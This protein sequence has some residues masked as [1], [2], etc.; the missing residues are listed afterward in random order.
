MAPRSPDP[1]SG[2][3]LALI[4]SDGPEANGRPG[5]VRRGIL[6]ALGIEFPD[7]R[8]ERRLREELARARHAERLLSRVQ[9][10]AERAHEDWAA[11]EPLDEAMAALRAELR[12]AAELRV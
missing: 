9:T 7:P 6:R 10:A 3:A 5:A 12:T 8:R 11:D 1:A 4:P 2:R